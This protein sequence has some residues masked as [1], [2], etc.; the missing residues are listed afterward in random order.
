MRRDRSHD[1]P[2]QGRAPRRVPKRAVHPQCVRTSVHTR[3]R[4]NVSLFS[5]QIFFPPSVCLLTY[6]TYVRACTRLTRGIQAFR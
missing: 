2:G 5:L 6:A 4:L 1:I 3:A